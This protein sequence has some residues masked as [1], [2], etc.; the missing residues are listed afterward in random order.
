MRI[1]HFHRL[2]NTNEVSRYKHAVYLR[3]LVVPIYPAQ[4]NLGGV[5]FLPE[6]HGALPQNGPVSSDAAA[7]ITALFLHFTNLFLI[8]VVCHNRNLNTLHPANS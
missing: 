2:Y 7:R 1:Y 5:S 4:S 6:S 8:S 3:P